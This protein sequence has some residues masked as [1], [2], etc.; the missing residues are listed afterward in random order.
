[1]ATKGKISKANFEIFKF[2]YYQNN[3]NEKIKKETIIS[4]TLS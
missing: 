4:S 2:F 3:K 1:M